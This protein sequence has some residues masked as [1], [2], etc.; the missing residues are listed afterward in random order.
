M[1]LNG[2]QTQKNHTR[3]GKQT[4]NGKQNPE[5]AK[6]FKDGVYLGYRKKGH[7]IKDYKSKKVKVVDIRLIDINKSIVYAGP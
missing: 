4:R 6:R 7:F 1:D 5:K 2:V 3:G